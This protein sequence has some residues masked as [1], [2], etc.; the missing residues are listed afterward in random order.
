MDQTI[1]YRFGPDDYSALVRARR[2]I[3]SLGR[4]GTR[5]RGMR[6]GL[7]LGLLGAGQWVIS[8]YDPLWVDPW[9]VLIVG[10]ILFVFM[11]VLMILVAPIGERLGEWAAARWQ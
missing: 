6:L 11:L 4:F 5:G 9:R 3:G 10:A 7:L 8:H 1:S 2:S